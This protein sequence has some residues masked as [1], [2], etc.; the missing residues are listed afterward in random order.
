MAIGCSNGILYLWDSLKGKQIS[1]IKLQ[2]DAFNPLAQSLY[3]Q[4]QNYFRIAAISFK[5]NNIFS[6]GSRDKIISTFD[7]RCCTNLSKP[8]PIGKFIGH[9]EEICGLKWSPDEDQLASGGNDNKVFIW[10]LRKMTY[11]AKFTKH[12]AAI[13]AMDWSQ[14]S[15]GI[16]ATGGGHNDQTIQ[17]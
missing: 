14:H 13:K 2:T 16:L 8:A 17:F 6:A 1:K 12:K 11:E 4:N 10:N 7:S 3:N 5:N 15:R 9:T